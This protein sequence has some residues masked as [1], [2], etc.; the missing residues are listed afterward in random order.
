MNT[1]YAECFHYSGTVLQCG[2]DFVLRRDVPLTYRVWRDGLEP[3]VVEVEENH[4]RLCGLENEVTELLDLEAGLEGQLKLRALDHDVREVEQM[5]LET[6]M[7]RN[8]HIKHQNLFIAAKDWFSL[9]LNAIY[10]YSTPIKL[11]P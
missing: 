8:K 5:H 9:L 7:T 3:I 10:I 11:N 6:G 1:K 2:H 4:L